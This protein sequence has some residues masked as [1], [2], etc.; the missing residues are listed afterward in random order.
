M[1]NFNCDRPKMGDLC[2]FL[3]ISIIKSYNGDEGV[4]E[5]F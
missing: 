2:I 3:S 1:R 5:G 4:I